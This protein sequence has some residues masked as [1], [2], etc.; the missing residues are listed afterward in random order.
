MTTPHL[1]GSRIK[2]T[3]SLYQ[4]PPICSE[5]GSPDV[6]E[7]RR[8]G[9][10]VCTACGLQA[11]GSLIAEESEWRDFEDDGPRSHGTVNSRVGGPEGGLI[12]LGL[13]T[14]MAQS[15][16]LGT[17]LSRLQ[18]KSTHS[19]D[20]QALLAAFHNAS[21]LAS[22]L[23]LPPLIVD[24]TN[25]LYK[26][27]LE[28][29]VFKSKKMDVALVACL[30]I[31]CRHES[32][33]R[34]LKEICQ[35]ATG[36]GSRRGKEITLKEVAKAFKKIK[37][38]RAYAAA[39]SAS[40][41]VGTNSLTSSNAEAATNAAMSS[42]SS[43]SAVSLVPRFCSTLK[44]PLMVERHTIT[45]IEA[46]ER[47]GCLEGR[48]PATIAAAAMILASNLASINDQTLKQTVERAAAVSLSAA[49]TIKK[50]YK[51]LHARRHDIVPIS[52]ASPVLLNSIEA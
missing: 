31:A 52:I 46:A 18:S 12:D 3:D 16:G 45:I 22:S 41:Q 37:R 48:A 34:T 44:L 15:D 32:V 10:L 50:A 40:A 49:G 29:G 51:E 25:H 23:S 33:P 7:D 43:A 8:G 42:S 1:I 19:V 47:V 24:R 5:C 28:S 26:R 36:T 39:P 4:A 6:I 13:S 11:G 27:V 17:S 14:V 20:A 2:T 38:S 9:Q 21:R 35:S 30:Y